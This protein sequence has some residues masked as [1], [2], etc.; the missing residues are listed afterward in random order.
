[1][2][3]CNN[4]LYGWRFNQSLFT[5]QLVSTIV[6]FYIVLNNIPLVCI[7]SCILVIRDGST[8]QRA[9]LS[10]NLDWPMSLFLAKYTDMPPLYSLPGAGADWL[11]SRSTWSVDPIGQSIWLVSWS[12]WSVNLI[13]Q[14]ISLTINA[15]LRRSEVHQQS[16]THLLYEWST[17][18]DFTQ[19]LHSN[20]TL[21]HWLH[22]AIH[23]H[24]INSRL[25][26][27]EWNESQHNSNDWIKIFHIF[28]V[29]IDFI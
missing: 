26:I 25:H 10:S 20:Y 24:T 15:S 21:Y 4:P 29:L 28:T 11:V 18:D 6:L 14:S 23:N 12:D 13:G 1:M 9:F 27:V 3:A 17:T 5:V 8:S 7:C 22:K 16:E 2:L 19:S